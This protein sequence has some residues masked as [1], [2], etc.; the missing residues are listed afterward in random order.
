MKFV[1]LGATGGTGIEIVK[2]AIERGHSVT[3]FVRS[4]QR[5][6]PFAPNV[7]IIKGSPLNAADLTRVI[8]GHDAVLSAFGPRDPR[9]REQLVA[10]FARS[11]TAAMAESDVS[12]L[13]ILSVAFL[14]RDSVLPPTYPF[15]QLLFK[16]H[17]ADC[18][19]METMVQES[20]LNWTIVRPPQLTNKTRSGKSR[21]RIGHLP[22]MGFT[23]SRANVGDFMVQAMEQ[24]SYSRQIVGFSD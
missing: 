15:G 1:V 10:P 9:S 3:A 23:A 2:R 18:A 21:V 24:Q 4:G 20:G 8:S 5:L 12:R 13:I 6:A 16:Y 7:D 17:V 19:A 11:L 22:F 14:F